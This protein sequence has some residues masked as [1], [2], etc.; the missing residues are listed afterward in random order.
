MRVFID[1]LV[2]RFAEQ[3]RWF[4]PAKVKSPSGRTG[5]RSSGP[6]T[7]LSVETGFG[8]ADRPMTA[9]GTTRPC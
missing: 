2:D 5:R 9:Y 3:Q 7:A 1:M 8:A 6:L 4:R